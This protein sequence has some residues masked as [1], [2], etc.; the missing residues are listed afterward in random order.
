MLCSGTSCC[1]SS[2]PKP[3]ASH[4]TRRGSSAP[5]VAAFGFGG[6][7]GSWPQ[8]WLDGLD[9]SDVNGGDSDERMDFMWLAKRKNWDRGLRPSGSS[10]I[11][12]D[13]VA[14]YVIESAL[15]HAGPE[16]EM[17]SHQVLPCHVEYGRSTN[18]HSKWQQDWT[19]CAKL[20][21]A[22]L[23]TVRCRQVMASLR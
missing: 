19:T 23:G 15:V 7:L 20:D 1:S 11:F 8:M 12:S 17:V 9:L 3:S 21:R 10:M 22:A 5:F 4:G 2:V 14:S 18:Y 6:S 16:D 13:E